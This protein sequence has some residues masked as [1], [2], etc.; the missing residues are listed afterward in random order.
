M[1]GERWCAG[2]VNEVDR[3]ATALSQLASR[4]L[5][6]LSSARELEGLI[7]DLINKLQTTAHSAARVTERLWQEIAQ[8]NRDQGV[9]IKDYVGRTQVVCTVWLCDCVSLAEFAT[10]A[11]DPR[12]S[13]TRSHTTTITESLDSKLR[14]KI[15][16]TR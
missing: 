5:Q 8:L 10:K 9:R 14:D 6:L 3:E 12:Y 1:L 15:K 16:T 13:Q 4:I 11:Q 2:D 7:T